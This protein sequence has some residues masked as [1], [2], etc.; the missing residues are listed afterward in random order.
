MD[1]EQALTTF[2]V[3]V[4]IGLSLAG[5]VR[6]WRSDT[7]AAQSASKA[8]ELA[9]TRQKIDLVKLRMDIEADLWTRI[10]DKV[11]RQ[12]ARIE[13]LEKEN[14]D[15]RRQLRTAIETRDFRIGELELRLKQLEGIIIRLREQLDAYERASE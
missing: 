10:K 1:P 8:N 2:G 6:S 4:A 14:S 5:F 7:V 3:I 15:L 11:D 12:D 13:R 9:E